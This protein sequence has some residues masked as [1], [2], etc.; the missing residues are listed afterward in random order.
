MMHVVRVPWHDNVAVTASAGHRHI[1]RQLRAGVALG[2]AAQWQHLSLSSY[3]GTCL[4]RQQH[5]LSVPHFIMLQDEHLDVLPNGSHLSFG[6]YQE[7]SRPLR[8]LL[9]QVGGGSIEGGLLAV[10][11]DPNALRELANVLCI[12][13]KAGPRSRRTSSCVLGCLSHPQ[14]LHQD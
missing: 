1:L 7:E 3:Q 2:C 14:D 4:V 13:T 5:T 10:Q 12:D 8:R 11:Q 9:K 6:S